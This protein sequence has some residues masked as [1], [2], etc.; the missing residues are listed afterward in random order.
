MMVEKGD[1]MNRLSRALEE[2]Q[3]QCR[4]LMASNNGQEINRL[5]TQ[6]RIV[7][8]EKEEIGKTVEELQVAIASLLIRN[9]LLV[10]SFSV[11]IA[12]QIGTGEERHIP[13]RLASG[14]DLRGRI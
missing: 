14:N 13:V 6:L 9:S 1:T 5:Q 10:L 12:A 2:S 8:E 3:A 4:H 11:S 7:T